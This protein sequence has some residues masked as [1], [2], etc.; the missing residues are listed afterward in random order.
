ML[1]VNKDN[2]QS[3]HVSPF[4]FVITIFILS[5]QKFCINCIR[6]MRVTVTVRT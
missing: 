1:S 2:I 3:F 6:G 5:V 4:L